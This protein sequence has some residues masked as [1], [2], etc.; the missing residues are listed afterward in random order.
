MDSITIL[1][2]GSQCIEHSVQLVGDL[3]QRGGSPVICLGGNWNKVCY[4]DTEAARVICRQLGFPTG[5]LWILSIYR[6]Y[7]H[8]NICSSDPKTHY[9]LIDRFYYYYN[10]IDWPIDVWLPYSIESVQCT[11]NDTQLS[12]CEYSYTRMFSCFYITDFKIG[13]Q[14]TRE[15]EDY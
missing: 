4:V 9:H 3:S 13:C 14:I 7:Y 5:G 2:A 12:Q 10:T 6:L 11:P 1:Y 15:S 8:Y